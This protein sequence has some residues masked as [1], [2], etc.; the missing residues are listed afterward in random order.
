MSFLEHTHTN[1]KF[2]RGEGEGGT[3]RR[4]RPGKFPWEN[5]HAMRI[6]KAAND[7]PASQPGVAGVVIYPPG[8]QAGLQGDAGM[9]R[10]SCGTRKRRSRR[11]GTSRR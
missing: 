10:I 7:E 1:T 4:A 9:R 8:R 6:E 3:D 2:I 5:T 11:G